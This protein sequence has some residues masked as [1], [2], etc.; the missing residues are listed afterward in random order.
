M[1]RSGGGSD[2]NCNC[3]GHA[4]VDERDRLSVHH[5]GETVHFVAGIH[6][7]GIRVDGFVLVIR[8]ILWDVGSEWFAQIQQPGLYRP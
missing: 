8:C 5:F 1:D 7:C 4:G 3:V 6:A 2:R